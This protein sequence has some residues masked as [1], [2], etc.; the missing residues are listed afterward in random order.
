MRGE[1]SGDPEG[2]GP[3]GCW[4]RR[5]LAQKDVGPEVWEGQKGRSSKGGVSKISR[6]FFLLTLQFSLLFSLS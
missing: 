6:C 2:W 3:E 4:P 5:V 1:E